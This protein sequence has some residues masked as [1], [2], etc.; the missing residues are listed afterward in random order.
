MLEHI[1]R[2]IMKQRANGQ[3]KKFKWPGKFRIMN[4]N[5][6]EYEKEAPDDIARPYLEHS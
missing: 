5:K 4:E 2:K 6:Q 3:G 1:A